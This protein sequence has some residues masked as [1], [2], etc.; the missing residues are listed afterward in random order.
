MEQSASKARRERVVE[1]DMFGDATLST[2]LRSGR[3]ARAS[4]TRG[5]I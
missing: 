1:V 2:G 4:M 3:R 5:L